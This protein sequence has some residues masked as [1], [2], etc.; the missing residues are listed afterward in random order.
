VTL[1][2]EPIP[3]WVR[4]EVVHV[5]TLQESFV[6]GRTLVRY[7][8]QN[9]PQRLFHIITPASWKNVEI[10]GQGIRR[11]DR[12]GQRWTI[13]M[14]SGV[15]GLLELT[16]AWEETRPDPTAPW[17]LAG[18]SIP[19]VERESGMVAVQARAPLQ[20]TPHPATTEFSRIDSGELP[21]WS[22]A[23]TAG[24]GA[25]LAWRY[26]RPGGAL[27]L[28]VQRFTDAEVLQA[29]VD[30][31]HLTTVVAD[32]GQLI[33]Q[34]RLIIR[35]NGRQHLELTL[36]PQ[37]TV[38]SAFVAGQPVRPRQRQ[39][40]LLLP[41]DAGLQPQ[42]AVNLE[43]TYVAQGR[44]PRI[45]GRLPLEAPRF[46][47]PL[48]DARWDF[49]LPPD[50]EYSDF[51]GSMTH[52]LTDL[53]PLA[54]DFTLAE[55]RRQ[56]E[57]QEKSD[58]SEILG[59]VTR[60]RGKLA[61]GQIAD[62]KEE[63]TQ[64]KRRAVRDQQTE[65]EVRQLEEDLNRAQGSNLI[66]AQNEYFFSNAL[67]LESGPAPQQASPGG[68]YS[69]EDAQRLAAVVQKAQVVSLTRVEPL[70][71]NLPTRGIRHSFTQVLQT[72]PG[73]PLTVEFHARNLRESGFF[74][75]AFRTIAGFLGL[76]IVA[77]LV[78]LFR[79]TRTE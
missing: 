71:V 58:A 13:E 5:V 24:T 16:V 45:R 53:S 60:A 1:T 64:A 74:T 6:T 38:W 66:Q 49:F 67:R 56:E 29:L 33:T 55:Y 18:F 65:Q 32:D 9:A 43:V 77:G 44:F 35:H 69:V 28:E 41:L 21:E 31:L 7:D 11:R 42:A 8:V 26:L 36:P 25:L 46:D 54:Q 34:L 57:A 47:L 79:P 22:G 3:P 4:A 50:Y 51:G 68:A 78:L 40:R 52:A 76:W 10:V 23:R 20:I 61:A 17:Q 12:E 75:R 27:H 2:T 62:V 39:N 14:Q 72:D 19:D 73:K 59:L 30:S 15:R 63:L 70:R 48:K 37:A